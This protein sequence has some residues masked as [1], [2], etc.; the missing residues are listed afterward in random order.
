MMQN[1]VF[2]I[3]RVIPTIPVIPTGSLPKSFGSLARFCG[4]LPRI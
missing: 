2:Y 3:T 4:R 1:V